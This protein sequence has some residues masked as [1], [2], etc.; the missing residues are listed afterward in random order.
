MRRG[1]GVSYYFEASGGPPT[2]EPAAI[3]F[4]DKGKVEVVVA[5]QTNG[6]G[7][8]TTFAQ[9]VHEHLGVPFDCITVKQGDTADGLSGGGTVGSRSLQTAGSALK[10]AMDRVIAKGKA[11]AREVLQAGHTEVQFRVENDGGR[12]CVTGTA[13]GI[14]LSELAF[15]L[16][17]DKVPAFESGLDEQADFN[18]PPTFPNGCHI[19]EVELDPET[20]TVTIDRYVVV[21]DVGRVINPL[22]V[23]GQIHGGVAQGLGQALMENCVYDSESGQLATATF[24]DYVMPRADQMPKL[25]VRYNEVPCLTNPLGAKGAGEAGTIGSL[26]ALVGAVSDAVGVAHIDMPATPEKIWRALR[27]A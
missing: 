9:L 8:E 5:T 20:G 4:L 26:P 15:A 23:D 12:F 18:S 2:T 7:H 21:D 13:R 24:A 22:I 1:R 3:R 10:I 11:A 16:Q 25:D 14:S 27:G 6:Q 17:Q 19:C